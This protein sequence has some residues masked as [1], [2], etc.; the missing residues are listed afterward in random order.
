M[1]TL[2][3][4]AYFE[5]EE[6]F[7]R[8]VMVRDKKRKGKRLLACLEDNWTLTV[9]MAPTG[10][11]ILDHSIYSNLNMSYF[12]QCT[13]ARLSSVGYVCVGRLNRVEGTMRRIAKFRNVKTAGSLSNCFLAIPQ[14]LYFDEGGQLMVVYHKL[15]L[16]KIG[17]IGVTQTMEKYNDVDSFV[18]NIFTQKSLV[19]LESDVEFCP[20]NADKMAVE[21]S[22]NVT[23]YLQ[24]VDCEE[25]IRFVTNMN[26]I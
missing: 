2:P 15:D 19:M 3:K 12:M 16:A 25:V 8:L 26:A 23:D 10:L 17:N 24:S 5:F 7:H 18:R 14:G 4:A 13:N 22:Q 6:P 9:T 11:A 1:A 21:D 20:M